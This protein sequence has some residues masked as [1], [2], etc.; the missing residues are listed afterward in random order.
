MVLPDNEI[1]QS[2]DDHSYEFIDSDDLHTDKS[3]HS[4][5]SFE[6]I[7][8]EEM[9][10]LK[11]IEEPNFAGITCEGNASDILDSETADASNN[12]DD[13]DRFSYKSTDS[14]LNFSDECTYME[15]ASPISDLDDKLRRF[16]RRAL[17]Y[18]ITDISGVFTVPTNLM[19]RGNIE[20]KDI[21]KEFILPF[22]PAKAL[23]R[24][25]AV[26]KEW[27]NRISHPFL[28]HLQ[29][30]CFE[31]MSGFFCQNGFQHFFVTLDQAAYGIPNS[32]LSFLPSNFKIKS[33]C[34]GLLLCQRVPDEDE[35]NEYCVCNPATREFHVLPQSTY[36]HGPEPN[37]ILA[38]EPSSMNFGENYKVICA[39]D[40]HDGF[41]M[42][43]F[44]IYNS[45]TKSWT[46]CS[47][48]VC[49]EFEVASLE[50]NGLYRNGVAYWATT[51]GYLLALDI[52]NSF[53]QVQPICS[54]RLKAE[55]IL[56]LLDGELSY[57]QAYVEPSYLESGTCC[58]D[59]DDVKNTCI[60]EIFGGVTM[61]LRRRV[62]V[63]LDMKIYDTQSFKVLF[64]PKRDFFIF[65]IENVLYSCNVE[66][67]KFE[68]IRSRSRGISSST[69]YTPYV[70]SLV[71]L[72]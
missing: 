5:S 43:C 32:T 57:I 28:A 51:L 9:N 64:A 49:P 42:L 6:F 66:E 31:E 18:E 53:Y 8:S 59:T 45:E 63:K 38:F 33:S 46:C 69:T 54:E 47:D 30:Y 34:K 35:E 3:D 24:F 70:N 71:S 11:D 50:D 62:T 44:D 4:E 26:S 20:I 39:F 48:L 19:L 12:L 1:D 7:G 55:G 68:V 10:S 41:K 58:D 13:M 65:N 72:A 15:V 40:M 25:K 56:T 29:S 27:D 17:T 67:K 37:L 61:R 23:V 16:K 21:A 52:K 36:Y 22:L 2:D 60:I 14:E